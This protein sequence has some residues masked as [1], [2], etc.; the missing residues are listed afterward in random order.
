MI[1][2]NSRPFLPTQTLLA[3]LCLVGFATPAM[4]AGN[5]YVTAESPGIEQSSLYQNPAAYG[6]IDVTQDTFNYLAPGVYNRSMPFA[7]NSALGAYSNAGIQSANQYGG[8]T[9]AGNYFAVGA[10][11]A[12]TT[13][14]L[15]LK[16]PQ[17]YFGFW[18]SALD[19]N[20]QLS[21]YSDQSLLGSFSAQEVLSFIQRQ[22]NAA[23]YFGNPNAKFQ[24][25]DKSEPFAYLNF[26]VAPNNSNL[27][28]NRV[29]FDNNQ[30]RGSGFEA[31]NFTIATN[32]AS[33]SGKALAVPFEPSATGGIL[34][35]AFVL[36]AEKLWSLRL[37]YSAIKGFSDRPTSSSP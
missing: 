8:A 9:G 17:R 33:T 31:D 30:S 26:F 35:L 22:P 5:L 29:V 7:G 23:Q 28:F 12:A 10:P 25:Q 13:A 1:N 21:F 20:N 18:L 3:W 14:T 27:T 15:S 32:Y 34:F 19:R 4:A 6:A 11:F 36:A 37:K 24:G 16:T 2:I